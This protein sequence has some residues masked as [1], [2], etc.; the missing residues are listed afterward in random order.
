MGVGLTYSFLR[1]I[2][3]PMKSRDIVIGIVILVV[4][5][6]VIYYRQKNKAMEQ[7]LVP[8]T[9]SIEEQMEDRFKVEIP[10][11]ASKTELTDVTLGNASGI[12]IKSFTN[13]KFEASVLAD[14]PEV[15]SGEF[16]QAWVV[17]GQRGS[18]DYSLVSLGKM[19]S[20]KGGWMIEF[21]ST[22]DYSSYEMFIVTKEK[23]FDNTPETTVLEGS[24]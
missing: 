20:A 15:A 10:D 14:L 9:L 6:G 8:Q 2:L 13:G 16:Y 21:Q 19:K 24:F 23:K 22:T 1:D 18:S 7:S 5:G 11:D 12:A 4:L 3:K 17:K